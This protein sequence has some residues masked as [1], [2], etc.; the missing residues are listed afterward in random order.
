MHRL[1]NEGVPIQ[2]TASLEV[3]VAVTVCFNRTLSDKTVM[4]DRAT[5]HARLNSREQ[6]V[7]ERLRRRWAPALRPIRLFGKATLVLQGVGLPLL[8]ASGS[9]LDHLVGTK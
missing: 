8:K 9:L 5:S 6:T 2:I 3:G 7:L 1:D 4:D